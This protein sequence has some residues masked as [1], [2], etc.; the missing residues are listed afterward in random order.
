MA[1]TPL[2]NPD[3]TQEQDSNLQQQNTEKLPSTTSQGDLQSNTTDVNSLRTNELKVTT[4]PVAPARKA[5]NGTVLSII[6]VVTILI[7]AGSLFIASLRVP[8]EKAKKDEAAARPSVAPGGEENGS[9][10]TKG[11]SKRQLKKQRKGKKK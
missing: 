4:G 1:A 3:T 2:Q 10:G 11:L 7:V 6:L 9:L 8:D 5:T